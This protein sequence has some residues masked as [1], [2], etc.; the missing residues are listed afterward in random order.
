MSVT[1]YP[2][3]DI[4][5]GSEVSAG[6]ASTSVDFGPALPGDHAY[7]VTARF[8]EAAGARSTASATLV[9]DEAAPTST[10]GST[11]TTAAATSSSTTVAGQASTSNTA[12]A[13]SSDTGGQGSGNGSGTLPYTGLAL[14]GVALLGA[15][16]LGAGTLL[17]RAARHQH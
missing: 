1:R 16:A 9:I 4:V 12:A 5:T 10:T 13:T 2:V 11:T 15:I 3:T 6:A 7:A 14:G 17:R 8:G